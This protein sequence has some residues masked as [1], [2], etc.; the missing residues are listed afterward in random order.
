MSSFIRSRQVFIRLA[1]AVT[2][3]L[4]IFAS[5]SY[6]GVRGQSVAPDGTATVLIF[7]T[8]SSMS[9]SDAS[10][11]TKLEAA[12]TAGTSILNVIEA[13]NQLQNIPIHQVGIVDFNTQTRV[14][15]PLSSDFNQARTALAK[16]SPVL[17]TGMPDGLKSG[18]DVLKN[19]PAGKKPII[20]LLSD[21]VPNVGLNSD[22]TASYDTVHSQ[23]MDLAGQAG[24]LGICIYTVGFG[25]AGSTSGFDEGLLQ[26]VAQRSGCGKYYNATDATQLANIYVEL[27]HVSTGDILLHKNGQIGQN[28]NVDLGAVDV[29]SNQE[30]LLFT[31]NWPGSKIEVNIT[32]PSGK[33]VDAQYPGA[34][35]NIS[36]SLA[37]IVVKSPAPGAWK[38]NLLGADVPEKIMTYSAILSTRK[39]TVLQSAVVVTVAPT[40][41]HSGDLAIP[42]LIVILAGG[43]V[44]MFVY[45]R[46]ITTRRVR[47][48][49]DSAA[50]LMGTAGPLAGQSVALHMETRM[51]R[52]SQCNLFLNDPTVSRLHASIRQAQGHWFIQDQGSAGG[53][54]VNGQKIQAV[55][56]RPGDQIKI[57]NSTFIFQG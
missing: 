55:Q 51:G 19:V 20:I 35:L 9:D 43:G 24:T 32:D 31:V 15:L 27:R 13:E 6:A 10:G 41:T 11:K 21:G 2:M 36:K 40:I 23:V 56:L 48:N 22:E 39:S 17:R 8:S 7:D 28:E 38:I 53:T 5:V 52:G 42:L 16:F 50:M 25:R 1:L 47:L 33:T 45:Y 3:A 49:A 26:E 4:A 57:G 54:F 46:A 29:S 37:S 12:Q 34:K 44:A 18:L 30:L 14:D